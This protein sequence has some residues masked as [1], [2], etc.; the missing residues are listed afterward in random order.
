MLAIKSCK[1]SLPHSNCPI[2]FGL[3]SF[4]RAAGNK[5]YAAAPPLF[6]AAKNG[7]KKSRKLGVR[8]CGGEEK[9]GERRTFLSLE[10]AGL[11]EISG[12]STHERFLC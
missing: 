7:N 5:Q 2:N 8:G 4:R 10:E 9:S 1:T 3:S 12:L 6:P 11:V